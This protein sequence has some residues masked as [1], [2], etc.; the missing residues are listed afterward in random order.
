[1]E[2]EIVKSFCILWKTDEYVGG[3]PRQFMFFEQGS[4]M[5]AVCLAALI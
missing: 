5:N 4:K 3:K 2:G 1:M